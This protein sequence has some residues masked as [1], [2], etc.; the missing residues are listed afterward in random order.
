MPSLTFSK[1]LRPVEPI[2]N[3]CFK[4]G[5]WPKLLLIQ[6]EKASCSSI[7]ILKKT[8]VTVPNLWNQNF[9]NQS[10]DF[11]SFF[12]YRVGRSFWRGIW[13]SADGVKIFWFR[14]DLLECGGHILRF[15][16]GT[17]L[18]S[19]KKETKEKKTLSVKT[20]IF[21][22]IGKKKRI[23]KW[24]LTCSNSSKDRRPLP[25]PR[26]SRSTSST[27]RRTS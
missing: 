3:R 17:Q 5:S 25:G 10:S 19:A 21:S 6:S 8:S 23:G 14:H 27:I 13:S 22:S 15:Q 7:R 18:K 1:R 24:I 12:F 4:S 9:K 20:R 26:W 2:G 16:F 11:Y